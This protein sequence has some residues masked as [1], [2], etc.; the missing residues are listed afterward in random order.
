MKK[1]LSVFL[2]LFFVVCFAK[3][4]II[5]Q[6][7]DLNYIYNHPGEEIED[8]IYRDCPA[9]NVGRGDK[10]YTVVNCPINQTYYCQPFYDLA[11]NESVKDNDAIYPEDCFSQHLYRRNRLY[12]FNKCCYVRYQL[13]GTIYNGCV[14]M[15][16]D[17]MQ[18]T[19]EAIARL[20][21]HSLE[22]HR[23]NLFISELYCKGSYIFGSLFISLLTLLL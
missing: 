9:Y 14:G 19:T 22:Y 18:D 15:T 3:S 5:L 8:N 11:G 21:E 23:K 2:T 16:D 13:E 4:Y 7:N 1:N 10:D 20:Q 6:K 17:E 12:Y